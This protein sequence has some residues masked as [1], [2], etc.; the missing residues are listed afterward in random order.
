[1]TA[2]ETSRA[3]FPVTWDR[4][5]DALRLWSHDRLHYPD[6]VTPLEFTLIEGGVDAGLTTAAR[7]YD[8]PITVHD[9]HINSYLYLAV[10]HDP[11]S[12]SE[13]AELAERSSAKLRAAMASLR[14]SW[15]EAWR[16]EIQAHLA[17][18]SGFDRAGATLP[19]LREHLEATLAHW[20]RVWEVHFLLLV[21]SMFAMSEFA[22]LYADLFPHAEPFAPYKLLAGLPSKTLESGQELWALSRRILAAPVVLEIFRTR[23]VADVLPGL[24]DCAEGRELLVELDR[25]LAVHGER[26]DKLSLHFPFWVED[27]AP[28]IAN[29]QSYVQQPDR[30][31]QAEMEKTAKQREELIAQMR[32]DLKHY[33]APV[34]DEVEF[35]LRAAQAGSFLAE[36]HGYWIDYKVSHCVRQVLLTIGAR[37]AAAEVLADGADVFYLDYDE[38]VSLLAGGAVSGLADADYRARVET[39]KAQA[40]RFA[41]I[42]PPSRLGVDPEGTLAGDGARDPIT[43]MFRK[44]EGEAPV[45]VETGE[46]GD[47]IIGSA[48]SPGVVEGNVKVVHG[49]S[50]AGKLQ[51]GDIL[52]ADTTAPPWTPL[53]ATVGGLVTN[54][55]GILSHSAV[56]AREYGIPAVVGAHGATMRLHDGQRVA[57]DGS[58]GI[59]RILG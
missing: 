7:S 17:W 4:P 9:R 56:V 6:P 21:P 19:A 3:E 58:L 54:S 30:D 32:A 35:F 55:G 38:V 51:P 13:K 12:A 36:E 16:P 33:P 48:G 46:A 14:S 45:P 28:V 47:L 29:L 44:I 27:P 22:D 50:E 25:Y 57:V 31:L 15:D 1:M 34:R 49:L 52:V 39:R 10:E 20:K 5:E 41:H 42:A 40:D 43:E 18:W 8:M 26:A 11:L 24:R 2:V 53:F 23:T 59:V 37:L